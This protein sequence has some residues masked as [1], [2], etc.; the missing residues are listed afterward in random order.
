MNEEAEKAM[1]DMALYGTGVMK[2]GKRIDPHDMRA[3][4][5][6][7]MAEKMADEPLTASATMRHHTFIHEVGSPARWEQV[8]DMVYRDRHRLMALSRST[9]TAVMINR[10]EQKH[11]IAW[12]RKNDPVRTGYFEHGSGRPDPGG[13][14]RLFGMPVFWAAPG[15]MN[16]QT[17]RVLTDFT[18]RS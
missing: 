6:A 16:G 2:D 13:D 3:K 14:D 15:S 7:E 4:E 9:A 12:L 1:N 10:E 17:V 8:V 18:Q 11:C 5:I